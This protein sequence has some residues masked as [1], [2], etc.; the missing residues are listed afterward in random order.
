MEPYYEHAGIT[1]YHGDA[2]EVLPNVGSVSSMITDPPY[3]IVNKFG[4]QTGSAKEGS[5][6]LE[7]DWDDPEITATVVEVLAMGLRRVDP[8]GSVFCFCGGDQFGLVM[9]TIRSHGFIAKPAVW[10]KQ[11]PPPPCKGNWWPS[12]FEFAVYGYRSGAFFGDTDPKRCNVF[13]YDSY[14]HGNSGKVDH[15]T[16]KPL[17][18]MNRL[19]TS[20]VGPGGIVIDPFAGSGSTLV[21]AKNEGRKAI[22]VEINERYCEMIANRLSQAVL[23]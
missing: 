1:L 19:V 17:A 13:H 7:F 15:P 18:L 11:C 14:R 4:S 10:L 22:G 5:R 6:A 20:I 8:K 21:A 12:G 9:S 16:Q 2:R 23:F 3:G